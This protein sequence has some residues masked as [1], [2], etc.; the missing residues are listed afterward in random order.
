MF[1][2]TLAVAVLFP[3]FLLLQSKGVIWKPFRGKASHGTWSRRR[4]AVTDRR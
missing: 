3:G 4:F 1:S 2:L